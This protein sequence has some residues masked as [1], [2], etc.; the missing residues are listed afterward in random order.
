MPYF[1]LTKHPFS[2]QKP[3]QSWPIFSP[4]LKITRTSPPLTLSPS[5]V[6]T[7][8]HNNISINSNS[9]NTTNSFCNSN[10]TTNT[11]NSYNNKINIR[12]STPNSTTK[13]SNN[14]I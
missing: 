12:N 11:N 10:N 3:C 7:S 6:T 5:I 8:R 14:T 13:P 9:N 4:S 2:W 1:K